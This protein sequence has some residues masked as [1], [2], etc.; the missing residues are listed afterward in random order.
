MPMKLVT[1]LSIVFLLTLPLLNCASQ[2]GTGTRVNCSGWKPIKFDAKNDSKKT[3][4]EILV[5]DKRGEL[6]RCW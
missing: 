3:I 4:R 1:K 2:S 6:G 5:H